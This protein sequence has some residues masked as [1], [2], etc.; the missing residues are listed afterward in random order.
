M[1][2]NLSRKFGK[3][4]TYD[5]FQFDLFPKSKDLSNASINELISC[6]LGYRAKFVKSVAEDIESKRLNFEDFRKKSYKEAK[7]E[8][9]KLN[10]IGNKTADCILLF[11]F[12]K[13]DAFPID[14]WIYRSLL[15]NYYWFFDNIK[16]FHSM[17]KLTHNQYNIIGSRVR[18]YFGDYCGY[19]QQ[20]LYYHIRETAKKTW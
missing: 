19:V 18:N 7:S 3:K 10:G 20:Y 1:L 9:I 12:E 6:N 5:G 15:E 11:S 14:V 2:N 4:V 16:G 13:L 8:L 17:D